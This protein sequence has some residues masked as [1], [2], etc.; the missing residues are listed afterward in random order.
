[1]RTVTLNHHHN[2]SND[3]VLSHSFLHVQVNATVKQSAAA[4][5]VISERWSSHRLHELVAAAVHCRRYTEHH[6]Q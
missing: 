2:S 5:A 6:L 3:N 1:M 4:A